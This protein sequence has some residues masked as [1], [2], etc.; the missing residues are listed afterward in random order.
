ML[1][2]TK[3]KISRL[4]AFQFMVFNGTI[5]IG[6]FFTS[7]PWLVKLVQADLIC[8]KKLCKRCLKTLIYQYFQP[9]SLKKIIKNRTNEKIASRSSASRKKPYGNS[10]FVKF[11]FRLIYVFIQLDIK[12]TK[13]INER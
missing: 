8:F 4:S 6:F 11:I 9:F 12:R 2:I 3:C 1:V 13:K 10:D 5:N 7:F